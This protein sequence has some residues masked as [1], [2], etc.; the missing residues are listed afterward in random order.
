[1]QMWV[2][3]FRDRE[4]HFAV[5]TNNGTES[6][7]KV[8]KY[9]YLPRKKKMMLSAI[10]TLIVETFLPESY[11]KYLFLNYKQSSQYR[12]YN[13]FVPDYL[14]NR[15]RTTISHCLE[16]KS[17][18]LKYTSED[19]TLIDDDNGVFRVKGTSGKDHEVK[20][21]IPSCS[22]RDWTT[23]HLPCKHFFC[24]FAHYPKWTWTSLPESYQNSAYLSN[25]HAAIEEYF[26]PVHNEPISVDQPVQ[27]EDST[28][29]SC[30]LPRLPEAKVR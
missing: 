30:V 24:I 27:S 22:C 13:S 25:D 21:H 1:M 16:R 17:K 8:F 26:Q 18:S 7:N 28:S 11:Q 20:F 12:T 3:A 4:F 10:I 29:T 23:W 15:P 9:H 19:I 5:N 6:L 2:R 14:H